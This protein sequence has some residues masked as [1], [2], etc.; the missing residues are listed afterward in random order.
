MLSKISGG[1]LRRARGRVMLL[2]GKVEARREMQR[3]SR[4]RFELR[5]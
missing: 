1:I 4:L 3:H 2:T 5:S